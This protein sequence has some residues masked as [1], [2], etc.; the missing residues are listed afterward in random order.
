MTLLDRRFHAL[1]LGLLFF[2]IA[3][4][5]AR[6]AT[7]PYSRAHAVQPLAALPQF[8]APATDVASQLASDG[9]PD[10]NSPL[11]VAMP[12]PVEIT[13][14]TH[15]A[16]E[17]VPGGRLWRLRLVSAGATDLSLGFSRF[18][19]PDGATLHL[20]TEAGDYVQGAFTIRDRKPH[21]QLWTP[22][23]PGAQMVVE[24]FVPENAPE[25]ELTLTQINCG[26]R[27]LFGRDKAGAK[28][29]SLPR[30]DPCENDVICP[31]GDPWR[32]EIRAVATYSIG[33]SLLCS[34][35]LINDVAGDARNF[36][37]TANHC[38]ITA[39]N[40][41]SI[42]V[43]WN[44]ESPA[45]GQHGGGSFAQNQSGA[46]FRMAKSDVDVTLIELED[47]PDASFKVYY[48]G[49]DRSG[50]TPSGAV[51]I[52]HP[53]TDEKSI[54]FAN[55][56]LTSVDSCIGT[57][58]INSHWQVIWSSGVTEPGSSGSGIWDPATHRL[59]G[60]LS[61]GD[62]YCT[63]PQ[64]P[65][66][67]GKFSTAWASGTTAATR[68]RDWLDPSNTG[69][70]SVAGRD[71]R[72]LPSVVAVLL[73]AESCLPTNGVVDPGENVTI[74]FT[75]TNASAMP[76][77]N[78]VATLLAGTGVNAPGGPQ[79]YGPMPVGGSNVSR[80]FPF[81]ATG[82]CGGLVTTR[83][84]LQDGT[85]NL[86]TLTNSFHLGGWNL[87]YAENFDAIISPALPAGWTNF[88][89]GSGSL[90]VSTNN[91]RDTLPNSVFAPAPS[92][93]SDEH[94]TS[95]AL[96]IGTTNAQVTFRHR[97][98]FENTYDGGV[99]EIALGAGGFT[100]WLAS[101][102]S[103][104]DGGYRGPINSSFSN[105]LAG[106]SAWTGSQAN[107]ITTVAQLPIA[108]A[109]QN[110]RLRWRAG[111]DVSVGGTGWHVDTVTLLDGSTCCSTVITPLILNLR[112]TPTNIAF[113]FNSVSGQTYQVEYK[114]SLN[115][116]NW[117]TL[118]T[119]TGQGTLQ[120]VTNGIVVGTNRIYRLKSP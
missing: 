99:L 89:S 31:A 47:I 64:A 5:P 29:S 102:G 13:P 85:N 104:L 58:G 34:G 35:T 51:G 63:T 75:L 77:T 40:A 22:V 95:P 79:T 120:N 83:L 36:F 78:L 41:P 28:A 115:V 74:S 3:R 94:L 42:V 100:D 97:Y 25:P 66:C 84:Q 50:L 46:T 103:F 49:W 52:H 12:V 43:Y 1:L 45:C 68:L 119:I 60:T 11:R 96:A 18:D 61:G 93:V 81:T 98:G 73:T 107:F 17:A 39:G 76:L 62:S 112:R 2:G 106:R 21:G 23:L 80:A 15:G 91:F 59:V 69:A 88:K 117:Q 27:D 14:A 118:Q 7:L 6:E 24:L 26:Y 4:L 113:S 44:Y 92:S 101:G 48:S 114:G 33:G 71:T 86:G 38:G 53:N 108:A 67:Y 70:L 116:T 10:K 90:W 55:S 37:L 19:L 111:T 57:G 109:G 20:Y 54:S 65:D 110:I 82:V 56:A 87:S 105:P 9:K 8:A 16:W 72:Q 30:S 32:H